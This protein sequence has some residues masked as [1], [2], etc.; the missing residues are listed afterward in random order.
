MGYPTG[1][2]QVALRSVPFR[3]PQLAPQPSARFQNLPR[4]VRMPPSVEDVK[5]HLYG[6][7]EKFDAANKASID[8]ARQR[9]AEMTRIPPAT[10][11]ALPPVHLTP[12]DM[13]PATPTAS[14]T[15]DFVAVEEGSDAD[16]IEEAA[17]NGE[18]ESFEGWNLGFD[19][20]IVG[21]TDR[22]R[23]QVPVMHMRRRRNQEV[24]TVRRVRRRHREGR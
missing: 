20:R 14:P 16:M 21:V 9:Q 7:V 13:E 2:G 6:S 17:E 3:V 22:L 11:R 23:R 24:R 5:R 19:E 1:L 10:T 4:E 8:E 12:E 18:P 15:E